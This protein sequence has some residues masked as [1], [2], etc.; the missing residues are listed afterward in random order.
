[1]NYEEALNVLNTISKITWSWG[2]I[3]LHTDLVA[4]IEVIKIEHSLISE[5]VKMLEEDNDQTA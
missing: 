5:R 1:M 4:A 2:D 3:M